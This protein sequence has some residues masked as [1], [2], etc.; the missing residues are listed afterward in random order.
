M[1][2]LPF[3]ILGQKYW[4]QS[5][6]LNLF[7]YNP[8]PSYQEALL[9]P[10]VFTTPLLRILWSL[11][12]YSAWMEHCTNLLIDIL[13]FLLLSYNLLSTYILLAIVGRDQEYSK[14][15]RIYRTT[16]LQ[17][18]IIQSNSVEKEKPYTNDINSSVFQI[19][20]LIDLLFSPLYYWSFS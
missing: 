19:S 5:W 12:S 4:H 13:T 1:L 6:F 2:F 16:S 3:Q 10:S 8:H 9:A 17:W 11:P 18:R 7:I 20:F 14:Y 15:L